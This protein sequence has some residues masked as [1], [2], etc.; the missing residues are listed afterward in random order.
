MPA[1]LV[2]NG[3]MDSKTDTPTILTATHA[4]KTAQGVVEFLAAELSLEKKQ[5]TASSTQAAQGVGSAYY[6]AYTGKNTTL[7]EALAS[8]GIT[9]TYSFRK[10]IA[11]ANGISG[12]VGSAA[13]NTQMYNL[14]KAGLLKK[15]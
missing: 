2:E 10:K 3:F 14:L 12:Y 15:A 8:L 9:Y 1:F 6:P 11:K 5:T 7:S 4:E 13:Q